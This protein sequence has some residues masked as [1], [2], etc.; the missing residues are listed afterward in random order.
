LPFSNNYAVELLQSINSSRGI[1]LK[2][3]E[4]NSRVLIKIGNYITSSNANARHPNP[5]Q[6]P[7]L[8]KAVEWI[9]L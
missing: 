7:A 1:L 5:E 2:E 6:N 8:V 3:V 9:V 4:R